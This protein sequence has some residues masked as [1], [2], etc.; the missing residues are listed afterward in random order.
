VIK[1]ARA[2]ALIAEHAEL[3]KRAFAEA[4]PHIRALFREA[5]TELRGCKTA[6]EASTFNASLFR[7]FAE[8]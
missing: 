4:E 5:E 1:T 2:E 8:P 6:A 3:R 7:H